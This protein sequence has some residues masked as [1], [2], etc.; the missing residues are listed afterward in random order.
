MV[1]HLVQA[2]PAPSPGQETVRLRGPLQLW[3]CES[4]RKR[5][6]GS[7]SLLLAVAYVGGFVVNVRGLLL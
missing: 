4:T 5:K 2:G 3:D 1:P 7:A 6:S